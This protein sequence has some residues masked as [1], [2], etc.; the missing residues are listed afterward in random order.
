MCCAKFIEKPHYFLRQIFLINKIYF[1][2]LSLRPSKSILQAGLTLP[3]EVLPD[4][5]INFIVKTLWPRAK[6]VDCAIKRSNTTGLRLEMSA[7]TVGP[8]LAPG[9]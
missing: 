9:D 5:N 3:S 2:W 6:E 8:W 1:N 7:Y 4:N